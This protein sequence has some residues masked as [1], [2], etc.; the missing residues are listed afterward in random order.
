MSIGAFIEI[1][2]TGLRKILG[3]KVDKQAPTA[4]DLKETKPLEAPV[5]APELKKDEK[6]EPIAKPTQKKKRK[7]KILSPAK[8]LRRK[9]VT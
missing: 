7:K 3:G 1:I 8:K 2:K 5:E 6:T 4:I 9:K